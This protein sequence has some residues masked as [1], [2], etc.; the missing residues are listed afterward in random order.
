MRLRHVV[1]DLVEAARDEVAELHLD[2]RHVAAEGEAERA[3][4]RPRLDDRRVAH[5]RLAEL[6]DEALRHLEDA[7]VL[8]D[9]LAE[10]D[11]PVV[12]PHRDAQ[13]VGYRVHVAQLGRLRLGRRRRGLRDEDARREDVGELLLD[14]RPRLGR[15]ERLVREGVDAQLVRVADRGEVAF[16]EEALL[17][18]EGL[19]EPDGVLLRPL[20]ELV[21][22]HVV[23]SR[24]LLVAAHAE[25]LE[26]QQRR[27]LAAAGAGGGSTHRA[28]DREE[29]VAVDHVARHAVAEA[30]VGEV[31]ARVLLVRRRREA[32]VVVLDH[33]HHRQLPDRREV[34]RLVEVALA[35]RAVAG[36]RG[37]DAVLPAQLRGEGE[38]VG[39]RQHRPEVADH[40]DDALLER[41]EVEGAIAALR[42]AALAAEQLP[43][44]LRQVE[45]AAGEDAEVAVHRQHVVAGL[46]GRHDAG[47][48]RLLADA[49][50]P[51]RQP[52]LAQQDEHLLFDHPREED[53]A[54][55]VAQ[56][57][58][59]EAL[60]RRERR[61]VRRGRLGHRPHC[62]H[63][64]GS[65]QTAVP[66]PS[67]QKLVL[68]VVRAVSRPDH[69]PR[70]AYS[71][72]EGLPE[73]SE[74]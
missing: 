4:D 62:R 8:R 54:V 60:D 15:G 42:E 16:V 68:T 25:R 11:D 73:T 28:H 31:Q 7:A 5:P 17:Q 9:V 74:R 45:V 24:R 10:E 47:R 33:E 67:A 48:D 72:A 21:L 63:A 52:P 44:Q 59:H 1:D 34:Q 22:R 3:A 20:G 35:R 12:A 53:R 66:R 37:G 26:L 64:D 38:A 69:P 43:K 14:G 50:E 49:R 18:E 36:E 71:I 19:V 13:A 57:L 2:H 39:H 46:E 32:P 61:R 29:V 58:G 41:A 30:A 6:L 23:G 40:A 56:L 55:E 65:R 70:R 51:L 27:S